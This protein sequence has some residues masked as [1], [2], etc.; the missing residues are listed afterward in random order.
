MYLQYKSLSPLWSQTIKYEYD[1]YF[2]SYN[3]KTIFYWWTEFPV[4]LSDM[5]HLVGEA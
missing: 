1:N 2:K 4:L 3:K 5:G